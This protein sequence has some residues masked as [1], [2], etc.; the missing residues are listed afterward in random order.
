MPD[1]PKFTKS[2]PQIVERFGA[3]MDRYPDVERRKM[4]GYP[5]AFVGGNMATGL[6]A[7]NWVVRMSDAELATAISE[8]AA[9]FE[10]MPGRPMKGFVVIPPAVVADDAAVGAW[11]EK[12]LALAGAMRQR[13]RGR[14]RRRPDQTK[15]WSGRRDLN[16]RPHRPER[17]ALPSC[18]TPRPNA[19]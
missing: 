14:A 13:S 5:A 6:F 7:E 1:M 4:F 16:P 8:G 10:V 2:S 9:P 12:G 18:A 17:C 3:V 19:R 11:V 15:G